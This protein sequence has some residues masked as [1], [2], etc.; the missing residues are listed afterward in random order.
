RPH[1]GFRGLARGLLEQLRIPERRG[2]LRRPRRSA[3]QQACSQDR[4]GAASRQARSSPARRLYLGKPRRPP[5]PARPSRSLP[6]QRR[7]GIRA[8]PGS[9]AG[10]RLP[11]RRKPDDARLL[12]R[13]GCGSR[14]RLRGP[15][16]AGSPEIQM[17]KA[18]TLLRIPIAQCF[19]LL[20]LPAVLSGCFA[21]QPK[22]PVRYHNTDPNPVFFRGAQSNSYLCGDLEFTTAWEDFS[23]SRIKYR[24][25]YVKPASF[26]VEVRNHGS[27]PVLID[28][29]SFTLQGPPG[30]APG[31]A[32]DPEKVL[33]SIRA[34]LE[35]LEAEKAR[36]TAS[37]RALALRD[38][39]EETDSST[40]SPENR[41]KRRAKYRAIREDH[42]GAMHDFAERARRLETDWRRW[43]DA[44]LRKTTL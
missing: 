43:S 36:E 42:K 27:A 16:C 9:R 38:L 21:F 24:K 18:G 33:L 11:I 15:L 5:A 20:A 37:H 26:R 7:P 44:A 32:I 40:A 2:R 28:P 30:E 4:I 6:I 10:L 19:F 35:N 13:R 17:V 12:S 39:D 14:H 41:E 25:G 29:G 3:A 1:P 23:W 8:L 34:D 31:P 22:T